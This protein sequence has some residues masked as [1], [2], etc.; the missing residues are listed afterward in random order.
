MLE[1]LALLIGLGISMPISAIVFLALDVPLAA[2][3]NRGARGLARDQA[4]KSGVF[5][6]LESILRIFATHL[7]KLPLARR[8]RQIDSAL[9]QAGEFQGLTPDEFMAISIASGFAGMAA[10]CFFFVATDS[11]LIPGACLLLGPLLPA[12]QLRSQTK[13]RY[14]SVARALPAA[15]DLASL[16]MG[17][18][19]DFPGAIKHVV[20]NMPN[21]QSAIRQE[22]Q[23]ILQELSLGRTRKQALEGLAE[24]VKSDAVQEFVASIVQAEERGTPISV[25]LGLQAKALRGRRTVLAEEAAARAGVLLLLPMLMIMGAIMLLLMGPLFIQMGQGAM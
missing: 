1:I 15:I 14:K 22:L 20:A 12:M 2:V 10:A 7:S 18:G 6:P 8:R 17:A 25:V 24:R 3:P 19:L 16:C 11:T 5:G 9:A 23:R 13:G 4:R 21:T